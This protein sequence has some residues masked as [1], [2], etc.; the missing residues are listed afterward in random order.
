MYVGDEWA[1]EPI[2]K[3][4]AE[5]KPEAEY[6]FF[7]GFLFTKGGK[8]GHDEYE[9]KPPRWRVAFVRA[10]GKL[11]AREHIPM[12]VEILNDQRNVVEVQHAA[13]VVLDEFGGDAA[14]AALK[15]ANESHPF[16]SIRL[17]AREALWKRGLLDGAEETVASDFTGGGGLDDTVEKIDED[18]AIVFIKGDND[19]PNDFQ[20]DIWRQTYSTTDSGPTYRLGDNL[21]VL[22]SMGADGK[23]RQLTHFEDGYVADCEVSWDGKKIVFARRGGM[24]DPW[25]HVY[26]IKPDGTGLR[27]LTDGPY[28]DVQPVYL[29]DGRIVFS[30]S[31]IGVR[32]EY[33][34]YLATGLTVMNGDGGD[35]HCIGFNLGRDNEPSV[36][37]DGRILFSRLELFYS[38]LK[39]ELTVH[40]VFPDGTKDVTL[41]GPEH[42]EYW[43]RV[44]A[45]SGERWWSEAPPRHRILRFTQPHYLGE[46]KIVCATTG[47]VAVIGPGKMHF[48][49]LERDRNMAVTSLFPLDAERILCAASVRDF[50]RKK[51]DL[52]IY[53]CDAETGKLKLVYNDPSCA[54]FEARPIAA[55][56][57]PKVLAEN[58]RSDSYVGRVFCH[59]AL[60]SRDRRVTEMGKF[61]RVIEGMPAMA[62]HHTHKSNKGEAWK[63]HTGTIGRILGTV[64]LR[65]DGSFYVEVPADRMIH[66]QVLDGDRRVV[67]NQQIWMY[68]R[69][70]ETRS[71]VGCHE[72]PDTT[73]KLDGFTP[74]ARQAPVPCLPT[75]GEF[76]Y[77]AKMWNKG[78]LP[79]EGEQRTKTVHAVNLIGRY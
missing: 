78:T 52:G 50:D 4:L 45:A 49:L 3:I 22:S 31:R 34:G 17:V 79:D 27:Q 36:M 38:R 70:D 41:H 18:T 5:S 53:I 69:P 77:R 43:R 21:Y 20:I 10:L 74:T 30:S 12:L 65:A 16:Y 57:R 61:V 48:K 60:T 14:I 51:V 6:G 23:V 66:V 47:G 32:D 11:G 2:A 67:G 15:A 39:T 55:R 54:D 29:G 63:N 24:K 7:G 72:T 28:H 76:T 13:A 58:E 44:S 42:R 8:Q 71:C 73:A 9:A 40:A 46:G 59:S 25:W 19:M 75:G 37:P 33:H 1:V 26:E 62:R 35:M 68:A 64:P 56:R